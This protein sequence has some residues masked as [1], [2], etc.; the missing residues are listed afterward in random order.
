MN[1]RLKRILP[2]FLVLILII[3]SIIMTI[4][5]NK[6]QQ[7]EKI[8]NSVYEI[9]N[10]ETIQDKIEEIETV[11]DLFI[12]IKD[13]NVIG[14]I[15][16]DKIKFEGLVYEGTSLDV[17]DKGV[18]HFE[19]TPIINGNVCFAAHNTS[20][21]WANLH[22]LQTNDLITYTSILGTKTYEVFN[23][24]EIEE[25]DWS[26]LENTNEN[27]ITLITCVKGKSNLRLCVQAIEKN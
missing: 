12:N 3:L 23:I 4:V 13:E 14:I 7:E 24:Q 1:T 17:L 25:T 5:I 22:T 11:E 27:I 15:K 21:Y 6:N 26:L 2:I 19:N 8:I 20:K 9:I 18:G 16:I 10:E